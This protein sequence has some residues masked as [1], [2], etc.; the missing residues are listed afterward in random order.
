MK[1]LIGIYKI[2][3]RRPD[4]T[5][6][7]YVG[8]SADLK[9]RIRSHRFYLTRGEHANSHLQAAW[10]KYGEAAF[11]FALVEEVEVARLCEREEFWIEHLVA[12]HERGGFNQRIVAQSNRG[13]KKSPESVMRSNGWRKGRPLSEAHRAAIGAANRGRNYTT[14]PVTGE[15]TSW[16]GR[17][18]SA[19]CIE[20]RRRT[21]AINRYGPVAVLWCLAA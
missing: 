9:Q 16:K 20:K 7:V 12:R 3:L 10:N 6:S 15:R 1:K 18:I 2:E 17:A 8:Q 4:G 19:E 21:R 14:D 13:L 11:D 5:T